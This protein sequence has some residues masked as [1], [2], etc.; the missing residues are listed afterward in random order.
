MI[1]ETTEE[2]RLFNWIRVDDLTAEELNDLLD[3]Y[4]VVNMMSGDYLVAD[5]IY[6]KEGYLHAQGI[7]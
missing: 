1:E 5:T 6:D 2:W 4:T 3:D 7:R